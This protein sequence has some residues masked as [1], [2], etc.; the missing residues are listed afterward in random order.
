MMKA[1]INQGS[2]PAE[3]VLSPE[4]ITFGAR[5]AAVFMRLRRWNEVARQRQALRNLDPHLLADIGL[6][7][8]RAAREAD[9]PFWDDPIDGETLKP[10]GSYGQT[11]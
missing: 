7:E 11:F 3:A 8:K 5:I 6:T 4:K 10:R 1:Q 2:P 9:R